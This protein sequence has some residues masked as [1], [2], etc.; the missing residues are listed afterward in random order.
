M[1][2]KLE[3]FAKRSRDLTGISL[4]LEARKRELRCAT[5]EARRVVGRPPLPDLQAAPGWDAERL[6]ENWLWIRTIKY[7]PHVTEAAMSPL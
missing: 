4:A 3:K 2:L 1:F 7:E 5:H 6:E